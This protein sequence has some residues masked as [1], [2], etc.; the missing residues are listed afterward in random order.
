MFPACEK[1]V[2]LKDK[3]NEGCNVHGKIA[4]SAGGGSYTLTPTARWK[5]TEPIKECR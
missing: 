1:A 2:S 5:R 4:L 3:E